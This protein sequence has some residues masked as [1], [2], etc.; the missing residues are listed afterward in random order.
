MDLN[1][2][3]ELE[4]YSLKDI[5]KKKYFFSI[6]NQLTNTHYKNSTFSNK[7]FIRRYTLVFLTLY[8]FLLR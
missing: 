6:I 2:Y 1:K 7:G 5:V 4:P 3:L 8:F